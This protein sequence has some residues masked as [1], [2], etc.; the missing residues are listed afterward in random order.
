MT[1]PSAGDTLENVQ[2]TAV[3][4]S[5]P[6]SQSVKQIWKSI[7]SREGSQA[8][9]GPGGVLG[10]KGEDWRSED[11]TFG[12]IRSYHPLEEV[13]FTWHAA[14]NAPKTVVQVTLQPADDGGSVVE[15]RHEQVPAYFDRAALARRWETFLDTIVAL[16]EASA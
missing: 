14:E 10:D 8:L 5:R 12:V 3:I 6:V 1:T 7:A 9:L 13:R 16:G 4:V 2:D 11:G 15:V